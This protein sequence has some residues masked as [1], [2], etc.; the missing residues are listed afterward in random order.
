MLCPH[1][2]H[3]ESKVVDSRLV[4]AGTCIRR[5]RECLGCQYRY[6]TYER[7][8]GLPLMVIKK[9]RRREP[10][11][12]RKL[13]KGILSAFNKRRVGKDAILNIVD[14]IEKSIRESSL[15]EIETIKIGQFVVEKLR[16]VD[17]VAYMRFVSVY[18]EFEGVSSFIEE[19]R[20]FETTEC[21]FINLQ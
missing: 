18:K 19:A 21:S 20:E 17:E 13:E 5:R 14:C 1:C 10:F 15:S 12:R 7:Y 9:D 16:Q 6:T 3:T 4:E 2:K 8:D 11:D